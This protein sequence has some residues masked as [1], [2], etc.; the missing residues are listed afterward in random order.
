MS[1]HLAEALPPLCQ[2]CD[3][4]SAPEVKGWKIQLWE[5]TLAAH[6]A[7]T[8]AYRDVLQPSATEAEVVAQ[9]AL[10]G[11]DLSALLLD[12]DGAV[13]TIT[14]SDMIEL[15]AA[16]S[17]VTTDG[18]RP[19]FMHLPN[20]PKGQRSVSVPGI[21]IVAAQVDLGDSSP[22]LRDDEFVVLCSVKHS[23]VDPADLRSKLVASLGPGTL[24][25]PY[26][27]SQLRLLE[28]KL[29]EA[30]MN[31]SRVYLALATGIPGAHVRLVGVAAVDTSMAADLAM[32]AE[33]LPQVTDYHC[34]RQ[35]LVRE[36]A[37]LHER[38]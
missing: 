38:I 28:G 32:Q 1:G 7:I 6:E 23:I 13:D 30:G 37:S 5:L 9:L 33:Y 19:E 18:L 12:E 20:V 8:Q 17:L 34:F 16:A 29:A 3:V 27:A 14:R 2:H 10:E 25:L 24:T 31:G 26:V 15:A 11:V 22:R 36:I 21:D 4:C 35:L